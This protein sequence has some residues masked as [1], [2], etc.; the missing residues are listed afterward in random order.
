MEEHET[1]LE[2][3]ER[4]ARRLNRAFGPVVAGLIIDF[5]DLATFG[6]LGFYVGPFV[7]GGAGYWLG[8]SLGLSR[9]ASGWC[10]LGGAVYCVLPMTEFIPLATIAGACARYMEPGDRQDEDEEDVLDAQPDRMEQ[11]QSLSTESK[12]R[13]YRV[14]P[15]NP[16]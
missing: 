12:S 8:R 11:E 6:P 10:A 7:G 15:T 2:G 4:K 5:L 14:T 9:K 16:E 3:I 13:F 1:T